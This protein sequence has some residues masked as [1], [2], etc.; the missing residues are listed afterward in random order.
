[1]TERYKLSLV[2]TSLDISRVAWLILNTTQIHGEYLL[3]PR[4]DREV[5]VNVLCVGYSG[6][7]SYKIAVS[8][9]SLKP[10][11]LLTG[12]C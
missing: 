7:Q 1:M 5:S 6:C 3:I 12:W 4:A 11:L 10:N 2:F 9:C 8:A